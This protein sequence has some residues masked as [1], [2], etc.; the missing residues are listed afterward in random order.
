[1]HEHGLIVGMQADLYSEGVKIDTVEV[2]E[3][4]ECGSGIHVVGLLREYLFMYL[5]E[6]TVRFLNDVRTFT[7][8]G[9][10]EI[11][12]EDGTD[13]FVCYGDDMYTFVPK[14]TKQ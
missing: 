12:Q 5:T 11:A 1:M 9:W 2:V 8:P 14:V 3:V 6:G 7:E 10:R 13:N 4:S